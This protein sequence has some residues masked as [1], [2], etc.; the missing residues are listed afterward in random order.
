MSLRY[1]RTLNR[2]INVADGSYGSNSYPYSMF[3]AYN[4]TDQ[5]FYFAFADGNI[6]RYSLGN[7]QFVEDSAWGRIPMRANVSG[8][9][10]FGM[11]I[12]NNIIY[13]GILNGNTFKFEAYSLATKARDTN[14]DIT[15]GSLTAVVSGAGFAAGNLIGAGIDANR[16]YLN[17]ALV[18]KG[19]F[20]RARSEIGQP[21][22]NGSIYAQSHIRAQRYRRCEQTPIPYRTSAW[23]E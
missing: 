7:N 17:H 23:A 18:S 16:I 1:T 22:F 5:K 15:L 21:G 2:V 3:H 9:K 14:S 20:T 4:P 6:Y 12:V 8:D 13:F 11:D 10:I 19:T